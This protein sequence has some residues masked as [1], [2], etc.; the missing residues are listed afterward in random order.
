YLSQGPGSHVSKMYFPQLLEQF[1]HVGPN[2][3]NLCYVMELLGPP[4][5][6]EE[7]RVDND[8]IE[9]EDT[10]DMDIEARLP[11]HIAW[12]ACKQTAQAV[13]FAHAK[14]IVHGGQSRGLYLTKHH[15]Q[16]PLDLHPHNA[17][18]VP[19]TASYSDHPD[20]IKTLENPE[21]EVV[22]SSQE[23]TGTSPKYRVGCIQL[24]SP[25]KDPEGY[26]IKLTGFRTASMPGERP[27]KRSHIDVRPP[28]VYTFCEWPSKQADIWNLAC[29]MIEF[30]TG[31][32]LFGSQDNYRV[33]PEYSLA[34]DPSLPNSYQYR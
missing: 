27:H 34:T 6:S 24:P 30:I 32:I 3:T 28:A 9:Q 12:E 7:E 2:G 14:G 19:S 31:D 18:F 25:A 15:L 33:L 4:V 23:S 10:D 17:V 21:V 20:L 22:E 11:G 13:E 5:L 16:A 8:D 1:K 26:T 29:T